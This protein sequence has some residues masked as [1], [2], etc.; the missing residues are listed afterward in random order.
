MTLEGDLVKNCM[1]DTVTG[2]RYWHDAGGIYFRTQ[3]F[4]LVD[5]ARSQ[6]TRIGDFG[7][8]PARERRCMCGMCVSTISKN[9]FYESVIGQQNIVK[10]RL[11][12]T[13]A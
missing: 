8:A 1:G 13:S 6:P 2:G 5:L 9:C 11:T 12:T 10:E 7:H 3:S 4:I